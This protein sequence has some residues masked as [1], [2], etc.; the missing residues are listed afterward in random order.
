MFCDQWGK[1]ALDYAKSTK[2]A[3]CVALLERAQREPSSFT[4]VSPVH[5]FA[6]G[7]AAASLPSSSNAIPAAATS[8]VRTLS[9]RSCFAALS[10]FFLCSFCQSSPVLPSPVPPPSVP[11]RPI[12]MVASAP[13]PF[14]PLSDDTQQLDHRMT[15]MTRRLGELEQQLVAATQQHLSSPSLASSSTPTS[16]TA[17]QHQPQQQ[18]QQPI[19]GSVAVDPVALHRALQV[20]EAVG[21]R[22]AELSHAVTQAQQQIQAEL[23]RS[24]LLSQPGSSSADYYYFFQLHLNGAFQGAVAL[25]GGLVSQQ[26]GGV[27]QSSAASLATQISGLAVRLSEG[28]PLISSVCQLLDKATGKWSEVERRKSINRLALYFAGDASKLSAFSELL[29]RR[30]ALYQLDVLS[31]L[32]QQ[33]D[34]AVQR[35]SSGQGQESMSQWFSRNVARLKQLKDTVLA[36]DVSNSVRKLAVDHGSA[37]IQAVIIGGSHLPER[38][39]SVHEGLDLSSYL[40]VILGASYEHTH[41]LPAPAPL[42]LSVAAAGTDAVSSVFP[43]TSIAS[44]QVSVM[45]HCVCCICISL[46]FFDSH[47]DVFRCHHRLVRNRLTQSHCLR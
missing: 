23:E 27:P 5:A 37:I 39:E 43:V 8:L 15:A 28:F 17:E 34:A 41:R 33:D 30:C 10:D 1:T 29:A 40:S 4:R 26:A 35:P 46:F 36:N 3:D 2:K 42:S 16:Q 20:A 18:Q 12:R 24:Q 7:V 44:A 38:V 32:Q 6:A 13:S 11:T 21:G 14:V 19:S 31:R 22:T 25:H 9:T 47:Y 45:L